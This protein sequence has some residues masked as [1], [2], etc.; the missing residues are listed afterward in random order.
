M[1]KKRNI[2]SGYPSIVVTTVKLFKSEKIDSLLILV[3]PVIR[4][5]SR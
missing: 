3:I 1:K 5:R 2:F 4:V